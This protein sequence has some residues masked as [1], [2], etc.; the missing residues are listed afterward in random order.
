ML[1]GVSIASAAGNKW[2]YFGVG[3]CRRSCWRS[4]D[5]ISVCIGGAV[6]HSL[7]RPGL[8]KAMACSPSGHTLWLAWKCPGLVSGRH[9]SIQWKLPSSEEGNPKSRPSSS[10]LSIVS[11]LGGS[12]H[13]RRLAHQCVVLLVAG[14]SK[15]RAYSTE[16]I[17]A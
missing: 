7:R 9:C 14:G 1:F 8:G 6:F 16:D 13:R 2:R 3:H 10:S 12:R 11:W 15:T 4:V 5:R 17:R